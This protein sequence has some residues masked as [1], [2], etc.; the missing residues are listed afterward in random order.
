MVLIPAG[1][2]VMGI[3][4]TDIQELTNWA[5]GYD[6]TAQTSWFQDETPRHEV[7]LDAYYIDVYEV[8]NGMYAKFIQATGNKPPKFWD[9]P[10]YN[11]PQQSVVGV[12][13][14]DAKAYCDWAGK[15]LPTEAEWE[16]AACGG[17][18]GKRFPWGD[19]A[20]HDYANYAGT[21]GSDV[22]AGPAPVGKFVPN[23]YGLYDMA[24]NVFEWC[25]DWYDKDYYAKSPK[26][27]PKGPD[28]GKTRVIRGGAFGYTANFMRVTD[29]FGS[30]FSTNAYPFVGFRCVK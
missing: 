29:R 17:L 10:K 7:Y 25:A 8:T 11:D 26:E 20:S 2:F 18:I 12:T 5:K 1:K 24:G 23:G 4:P 28:S 13:W 21:V 30:Y 27:N 15:R 3:N 22:W 16:K 14:E 19:E 6:P 9:D